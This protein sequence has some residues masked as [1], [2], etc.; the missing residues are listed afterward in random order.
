MTDTT[1]TEGT[2]AASAP[3]RRRR[4]WPRW[5]SPPPWSSTGWSSGSA[6]SWRSTASRSRSRRVPSCRSSA[7]RAA[8]RPR[9]C[10]CSP[11]SSARP[12]GSIVLGGADVT[13]QPAHQ[14]D[15]G[16]VFQ[17]L[18]LFPH[19]DVRR[20]IG[21]PLRIKGTDRR[22]VASRVDELLGLVH[23]DGLGGRPVRKLSGGQRQRVAIAARSR[24]SRRCSS[25]TSR[26]RR[27][28]PT[29]ARRCRS[30]CGCCSSAW[31]SRRSWSPTTSARP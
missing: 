17:S 20:N 11:A 10:G 26:C 25:S 19:L 31:G 9:C 24:A 22:T 3:R 28:T 21:Y 13:R 4:R 1:E 5:C 15:I 23:L 6:R 2:G 16:M 30:S 12:P 29:C 8:A 7:R 27:S 14:R 18:A